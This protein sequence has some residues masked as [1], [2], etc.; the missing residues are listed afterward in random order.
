MRKFIVVNFIFL[1][2]YTAFAHD[3]IPLCEEEMEIPVRRLVRATT[4]AVQT[5]ELDIDDVKHMVLTPSSL[6]DPYLR[7]N[8]GIKNI[9][10]RRKLRHALKTLP[11]T[12][13]SEAQLALRQLVKFGENQNSIV[14]SAVEQTAEVLRPSLLKN[15]APEDMRKSQDAP[16]WFRSKN[17]EL[18]LASF[19]AAE[20][21]LQVYRLGTPKALVDRHLIPR[22]SPWKNFVGG[23]R[24]FAN[25]QGQMMVADYVHSIH[26]LVIHNVELDQT[27][28]I[29]LDSFIEGIEALHRDDQTFL[30]TWSRDSIVTYLLN[31][32]LTLTEF[33]RN[34]LKSGYYRFT[35]NQK[36]DALIVAFLTD[37]HVAIIDP[38][39]GEAP[40]LHETK[41]RVRD[42]EVALNPA[43]EYAVAVKTASG[44]ELSSKKR[45]EFVTSR[46]YKAVISDIYENV[47]GG[48]WTVTR[49]GRVFFPIAYRIGDN[50]GTVEVFEAFSAVTKPS[51]NWFKRKMGWD[52][53]V[54]PFA[55]IDL[56]D[57]FAT[58]HPDILETSDGKILL[59]VATKSKER[60][61]S[62]LLI[63]D[64]ANMEKPFRAIATAP[65]E[66]LALKLSE[67]VAHR[68]LLA[69]T[70]DGAKNFKIFT[71]TG[72][73]LTGSATLVSP[74]VEDHDGQSY[75]YS[76]LGGANGAFGATTIYRLYTKPER[77]R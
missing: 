41:Y 44:N 15:S 56:K 1:F 6:R 60:Q 5:R 74:V 28:K 36:G 18:L 26:T 45:L 17:G 43:G 66:I 70:I 64:L 8:R 34:D 76:F 14:S 46:P 72:I 21:H 63:F 7:K 59:A 57:A 16:Q 47:N 30:V 3:L 50:S 61:E 35:A 25:S 38:L 55:K 12:Q 32:D 2:A 62:Q 42:F 22:A 9:D 69:T 58:V 52:E 71:E 77:P 20:A 37:H 29:E 39:S 31:D 53:T 10:L 49:D 19:G 27:H 48:K 75:I 65:R 73:V 40:R 54:M 51:P 68:S 67:D 13:L 11:A 24:I 23:A 33:K 4:L